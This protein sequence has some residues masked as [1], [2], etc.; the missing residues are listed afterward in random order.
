M[1]IFDFIQPFFELIDAILELFETLSDL[2][3]DKDE[4]IPNAFDLGEQNA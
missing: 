2:A 4:I 3:E 1:T